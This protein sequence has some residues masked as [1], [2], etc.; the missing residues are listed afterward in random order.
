A[1]LWRFRTRPEMAPRAISARSAHRSGTEHDSSRSVTASRC[2]ASHA[3]STYASRRPVYPRV[4]AISY[5]SSFSTRTESGP[6]PPISRPARCASA[7]TVFFARLVLG[8]GLSRVVTPGTVAGARVARTAEPPSFQGARMTGTSTGVAEVATGCQGAAACGAR[9]RLPRQGR[10]AAREE[11]AGRSEVISTARR[12]GPPRV[13]VDPTLVEAG[14]TRVGAGPTPDEA[15]PTRV[16]AGPTPVGAGPTP[17]GA[18]PTH[19]E[20]GSTRVGAGP[21]PDEAG[22]TRV[23]AGPTRVGAGPTHVGADRPGGRPWREPGC[24][25]LTPIRTFLGVV[26]KNALCLS[27]RRS[28]SH[29]GGTGPNGSAHRLRADSRR[30]RMG[31]IHVPR[32]AIGF[33]RDNIPKLIAGSEVVQTRFAANTAE[34]GDAPVSPATFGAQITDL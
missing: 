3:P 33:R 1:R 31:P 4:S 27:T 21:T 9:A 22:S 34:L 19:V 29:G 25:Y 16:G 7:S 28:G 24:P 14:P 20:A 12:W 15:G 8:S 11:C 26:P 30:K 13:G 18:G 2:S 10:Q 23:G 5:T 6:L 17:V 32:P